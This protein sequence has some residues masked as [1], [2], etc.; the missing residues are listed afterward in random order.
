MLKSKMDDFDRNQSGQLLTQRNKMC[1]YKTEE[2]IIVARIMIDEVAQPEEL[3]V[4]I[5]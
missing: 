5:N 1:K 4:G 2:H 3:V